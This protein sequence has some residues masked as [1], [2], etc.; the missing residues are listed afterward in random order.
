MAALTPAEQKQVR[1]TS[2]MIWSYKTGQMVALQIHLA[3]RMRM[4]KAMAYELNYE[5]VTANQV[6]KHLGLKRRWV[7]ELLRGLTAAKILEYQ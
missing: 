5:W 3:D 2:G 4:F 1:R 6:A 7:M